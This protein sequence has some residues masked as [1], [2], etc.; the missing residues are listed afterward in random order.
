LV[1]I[2]SSI[3]PKLG[4][5]EGGEIEGDV[6]IRA[7]CSDVSEELRPL[8]SPAK[9][10][11]INVRKEETTKIALDCKSGYMVVWLAARIAPGPPHYREAKA[12]SGNYHQR[13]RHRPTNHRG[14]RVNG[15]LGRE[16]I[17]GL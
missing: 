6:A 10:R 11:A 14:L 16:N 5:I 9:E 12:S 7:I 8:Q 15:D 2:R 3:T 13:G 17:A 4:E 1:V